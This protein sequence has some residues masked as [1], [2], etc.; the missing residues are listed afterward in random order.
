MGSRSLT[1]ISKGDRHMRSISRV[2]VWLA[3]LIAAVAGGHSESGGGGPGGRR[4]RRVRGEDD[5]SF[6]GDA[7]LYLVGRALAD[8]GW[9]AACSFT[10]RTGPKDNPVSSV[11]ILESR[12]EAATS[13]RVPGRYPAR[14]RSRA[15]PCSR[16]GRLLALGEQPQ[17]RRIRRAAS[18]DGGATWGSRVDLLPAKEYPGLADDHP[19]AP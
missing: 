2:A 10:Q 13:T 8:R 9:P 17:R 16:T 12:D 1:T 19:T 5:L 18:T 14:R 3:S 15:W 11:P 7:R 4:S 6:S